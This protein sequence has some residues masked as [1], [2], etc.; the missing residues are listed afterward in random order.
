[1][2]KI[3]IM[4]AFVVCLLPL[5]LVC[6]EK[7]PSGSTCL[8]NPLSI[9]TEGDAGEI[10]AKLIGQVIK[11]ALG[12]VGGLALVFMVWGGFQ[13]LTSAGNKEKVSQGTQTMLW[14]II[15]LLLVLSSYLMVDT[16]INFLA[17][18]KW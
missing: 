17:G 13:W 14:A 6:A 18:R 10:P 9:G 7:C 8:D 2:K 12:V 3:L 4:I 5:G 1:M 16:F 11:T 15:G